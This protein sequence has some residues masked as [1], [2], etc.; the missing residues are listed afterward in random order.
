[1]SRWLVLLCVLTACKSPPLAA[2]EVRVE[3]AALRE[4]A[5][6][7]ALFVAPCDTLSRRFRDHV[8]VLDDVDASLRQYLWEH[9]FRVLPTADFERTWERCEADLGGLYDGRTGRLDPRRVDRCLSNT[10]A[11]LSQQG[12]IGG[13]LL[14]KVIYSHVELDEPYDSGTWDGVRREMLFRGRPTRGALEEGPRHDARG[15]RLHGGTASSPTKRWAAST[16]RRSACARTAPCAS[17]RRKRATTTRRPCARAS[18]S[19]CAGWPRAEPGGRS[20][21]RRQ[22]PVGPSARAG[23]VLVETM[24]VEPTTFALRT[25][26]SAN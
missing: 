2:P 26:R 4:I 19:P 7:R 21:R 3:E 17:S 20:R 12:E 5:G 9:D 6:D 18:R 10:L 22:D 15:A 16:S 1:M 24:G 23:V 8:E 11:A 14:P 13:V 25:R